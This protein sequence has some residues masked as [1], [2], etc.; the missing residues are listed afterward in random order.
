MTLSGARVLITG[1]AGFLGGTLAHRLAAGGTRVRAFVHRPS[2]ADFLRGVPNVEIVPG[3]V[4]DRDSLRR[5]ITG[6]SVVFHCAA[7]FTDWQTQQAVNADGTR[8]VAEVAADAGVGRLVHVSTIAVYGYR[9]TG[10]VTESAPLIEARGDPYNH[11]KLEGE[12]IVAEVAA[13]RNLSVSIIRPGQMYGPRGGIWTQTLFRLA[14]QPWIVFPGAGSG[15]IH[16]IHIDDVAD[17]M[18]VLATHPSADGDAFNCAPDPAPTWREMLLG[19]RRLAGRRDDR[20]AALPA[21]PLL[22]AAKLAAALAPPHNQLRD[23]PDLFAMMQRYFSFSAARARD[24]LGWTPQVSLSAGI[25]SCA[26]WLRAQGLL[27]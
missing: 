20:W 9:P 7:A 19:Y 11:S 16:A 2:K 5:A 24:R 1:A 17:L 4:T 8:K 18:I 6:C 3:D 22:V 26:P 21:A 27:R 13:A 25:E 15:A 10:D 12:R 23:A 14:K